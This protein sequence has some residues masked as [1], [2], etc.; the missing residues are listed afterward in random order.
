MKSPLLLV[1]PCLASSL[2]AQAFTSPIGFDTVEGNAAQTVLFGATDRRFQQIDGGL[3][4]L[5]PRTI[6]QIAFRR[7]GDRAAASAVTRTFDLEV[8]MGHG[9]LATAGAEFDANYLSAPTVVF[10]TQQVTLPD[11]TALQAGPAAFDFVITL[12]TPFN[13]NGTDDLVWEIRASNSSAPGTVY[14]DRHNATTPFGYEEAVS[15]SPGCTETSQVQPFELR[16]SVFNYGPSHPS[17]GQRL[18]YSGDYGGAEQP[19]AL[20]IGVNPP[21]D[22]AGLLCADFLHLLIFSI[23]VGST[24]PSGSVPEIV[25]DVPYDPGLEGAQIA[26]QLLSVDLGQPSLPFI[27]SNIVEYTIPGSVD[28]LDCMYVYA[29]GTTSTSGLVFGSRGVI[30]EFQ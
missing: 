15:T 5:G 2:T 26:S 7:D 23:G 9:N 30:V 24:A 1:L 3:T 18:I 12:D 6:S 25:I 16:A 21:V 28:S 22:T 27:V 20:D 11:W 19:V 14:L 29:A 10:A 13:Y 17:F 4:A 8:R